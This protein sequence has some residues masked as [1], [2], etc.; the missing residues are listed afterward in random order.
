MAWLDR[1]SEMSDLLNEYKKKIRSA[2]KHLEFSSNAV[3]ELST[4]PAQLDDAQLASWEAFTSRFARTIDLFTTK[5]IPLRVKMEDPAFD[6]SLLDFL[7]Q[8]EKMNLVSDSM[9]FLAARKLRNQEAH[10]YEDE[11]LK[12]FF[13]AVQREAGWLLGELPT[14]VL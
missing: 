4:N 12:G 9:R 10:E 11:D 14:T 8:A 5:Y 3:K 13:E 2:L 6:G 1:L 7:N